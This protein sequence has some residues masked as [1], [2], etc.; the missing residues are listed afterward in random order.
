LQ[1]H[2]DVVLALLYLSTG[3]SIETAL[4]RLEVSQSTA[5]SKSDRAAWRKRLLA[6]RCVQLRRL[7]EYRERGLFPINDGQ[8]PD[9]L[10]IFVDG[11][12]TACA[13]GHLMRI[14]G[15]QASVAVIAGS[16]NYV[17]VPDVERGSIADWI[18][19]SGLTLE[20]AALIQPAYPWIP[21]GTAPIPDDAIEITPGWSG[22]FRDLRFSNFRILPEADGVEMPPVNVEFFNNMSCVFGYIGCPI[23]GPL[24]PVSGDTAASIAAG[25]ARVLIQ[26][27]VDVVSPIHRI[28]GLPQAS[29]F[30]SGPIPSYALNRIALFVSGNQSQLHIDRPDDGLEAIEVP[31]APSF[32]PAS[33][34]PDRMGTDDLELTQHLTVVTELEVRNG[35]SH[36][37]Q[38]MHFR[39]VTIPEPAT[40]LLLAIC[41]TVMAAGR[42]IRSRHCS[43]AE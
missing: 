27:D 7:T 19:T 2:F 25:S 34:P 12:D 31:F 21:R 40:W 5:W 8:A 30:L 16:D 35:Q 23:Q 4:N 32:P 1:D 9:S 42:R 43:N 22:V 10:P 39:V 11:H 41:T 36:Q 24:V 3:A 13:V 17:Y 37:A 26:F 14:S 38:F 15:C 28:V 6:A 33:Q 29:T 18:L 20:E